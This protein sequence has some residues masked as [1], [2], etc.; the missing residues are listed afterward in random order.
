[1]WHRDGRLALLH[2]DPAPVLSETRWYAWDLAAQ[3]G[4]LV[5]GAQG[6]AIEGPHG[7]RFIN[8]G[9]LY[10]LRTAGP[11]AI[12][13]GL[14][15]VGDDLVHRRYVVQRTGDTGFAPGPLHLMPID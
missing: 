10:D 14:A 2:V 15:V 9:T 7:P 11:V 12:G 5:A 3:T 4:R 13:A 1:M 8:F 6:D